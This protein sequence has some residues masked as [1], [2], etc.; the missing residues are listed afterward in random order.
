MTNES[1]TRSL[2]R[3]TFFALCSL[4]GVGHPVFANALWRKSRRALQAGGREQ[5]QAP[6]ITKEM[7]AAAATLIGLELS[8]AEKDEL[9]QTLATSASNLSQLRAVPLPNSVMPALR[10]M[11]ELPG[12]SSGCGPRLRLVEDRRRRREVQRPERAEDLAFLSVADQGELLR[13]KRVTSAE[14]T[15]LYLER[16][17]RH[18]PTLQCVVNL[19]KERAFNQARAA[20]EDIQAGRYRGPLHGIPWGAKDLFAVPGYPT[21]WGTAPYRDQV[22]LDT[23][24][25][26]E[27]LDQAG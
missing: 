3:R 7:V 27:R 22:L 8:D 2:D 16:L 14:L 11:A 10:F 12:K 24:T 1:M 23:A 4:A 13:S 15:R 21:T 26:V 5:A 18:G 6:A 19:T 20:D 17:E 25:V 9:V